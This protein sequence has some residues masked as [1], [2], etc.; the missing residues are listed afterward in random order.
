M[1]RI[2]LSVSMWSGLTGPAING[3]V[4]CLW[5]PTVLLQLV[6]LFAFG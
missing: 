3:Q 6:Q 4:L 5:N 2:V 1:R